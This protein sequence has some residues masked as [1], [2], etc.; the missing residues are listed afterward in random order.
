[1]IHNEASKSVEPEN[2]PTQY[3]SL[4]EWISEQ[5]N[6][7]KDKGEVSV[8]YDPACT[9]VENW[10]LTITPNAGGDDEYVYVTVPE[11][12]TI[13]EMPLVGGVNLSADVSSSDAPWQKGGGDYLIPSQDAAE[14]E[15]KVKEYEEV[16]GS[17]SQQ[18]K[19]IHAWFQ[20]HLQSYSDFFGYR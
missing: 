1:M 13:V 2:T 11:G 8:E 20:K 3:I 10:V 4:H 6:E 12:M 15:A 14:V 18:E 5:V 7:L 16:R 19:D 17:G 9:G